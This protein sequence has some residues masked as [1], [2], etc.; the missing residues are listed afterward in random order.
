MNNDRNYEEPKSFANS[1]AYG[2]NGRPSAT[3]SESARDPYSPPLRPRCY[4]KTELALLYFPA[5]N[6]HNARQRLCR[7]LHRC[8]ALWQ[9]LTAIGYQD[10]QQG[11]SPRETRLIFEYLG[12]PG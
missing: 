3:Y 2:E 9:A 12:E 6:P 4:D 10:S 8:Q 5:S 1:A 11:F 7:W